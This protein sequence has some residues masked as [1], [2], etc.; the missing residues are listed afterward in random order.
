M[1]LFLSLQHASLTRSY[2]NPL[3]SLYYVGVTL[4]GVEPDV[5]FAPYLPLPQKVSLLLA[6]SLDVVREVCPI[7][8]PRDPWQAIA[9]RVAPMPRGSDGFAYI[10]KPRGSDDVWV[11][12]ACGD[13]TL[14]FLERWEMDR[15]GARCRLHLDIEGAGLTTHDTDDEGL[16]PL[17]WG[18]GH[19]GRI[20]AFRS[21]HVL[22]LPSF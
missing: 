13:D 9:N 12:L 3:R 8:S 1:R 10:S 4:E 18:N 15:V 21:V 5:P 14:D 22:T 11:F 19:V 6:P 7:P 17:D 20:G 2:P 16:G